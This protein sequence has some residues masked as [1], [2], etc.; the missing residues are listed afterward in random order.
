MTIRSPSK[1]GLP[2]RSFA[3]LEDP[4]SYFI[5][6]G[7][8]Y[9]NYSYPTSFV[10]QRRLSYKDL[11]TPIGEEWSLSFLPEIKRRNGVYPQPPCLEP[12]EKGV[13]VCA[14]SYLSNMTVKD[15]L[16]LNLY[17]KNR[18]LSPRQY[19]DCL[20]LIQEGLV[21][22][23]YVF[24]GTGDRLDQ[25]SL[26]VIHD[27]LVGR[28][29][30]GVRG[31]FLDAYFLMIHGVLYLASDH[32]LLPDGNLAPRYIEPLESLLTQGR[33]GVGINFKDYLSRA[34]SQGFPPLDIKGGRCRYSP[35]KNDSFG[36]F[37]VNGGNGEF[38]FGDT[39]SELK[40]PNI[41]I[42]AVK[43]MR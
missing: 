8:D 26:G 5:L 32:T 1:I 3:G 22:N 2:Q 17:Y 42:R 19:I 27:D 24:D 43:P 4:S 38:N 36:N 25:N 37:I 7:R 23:K 13:G 30:L 6:D 14:Y 29:D 10:A 21:G 34:N 15:A 12:L 33:V 35:P 41:G 20:H 31:E 28:L 16:K 18:T 9:G 40:H 11:T 39:L